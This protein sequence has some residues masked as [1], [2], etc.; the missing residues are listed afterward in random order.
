MRNDLRR[1]QDGGR[2]ALDLV[3]VGELNGDLILENL[4]DGPELGKE[5]IA[6]GMTLTL[7]SSSAIL[8]SNASRLGLRVGFVGAI[9]RDS[10]G[11]FVRNA[12]ESAK[13]DVS[14][15]IE[16]E[17]E[18]TGLTVIY[19]YAG[20]RGMLTYPGAMASLRYEEL[21][22]AYLTSARHLHLS[23]YYLQPALRPSVPEMYR[24]AKDAGM[25]TSFDTNW[26]PDEKWEKD[27]YDVFPFVDVFLPND[28]EAML[29]ARE[30]D[31]QSAIEKLSRRVGTVVVT[32]G[33]DGVI[34][35]RGDEQLHVDALPVT[36]V[37]AVGAGD[38]FNAGFLSR[39]VRGADLAECLSAGTVAAA[40]STTRA[41]GTTAFT[42]T[43]RYRQFEAEMWPLAAAHAPGVAAR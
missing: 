12:L 38:S 34:A 14:R 42:E 30:N 1:D 26:D 19:T 3:V 24:A 13:V 37:D 41:G 33:K 28:A 2:V 22:R 10:F 21:P 5:R 27:I 18:A 8:A 17:N 39:F 25:T 31:V 7:G 15:L 43:E 35:R 32:C 4:N 16:R 40:F 23:S 29:I 9:G 36:P 20:D 11:A 6:S